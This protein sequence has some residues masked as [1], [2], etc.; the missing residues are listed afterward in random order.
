M[1]GMGPSDGTEPEPN[2]RSLAHRRRA[3]THQRRQAA[4]LR[5]QLLSAMTDPPGGAFRV[6]RNEQGRPELLSPNKVDFS[7]SHTDG[8]VGVAAVEGGHVGFDLER[9]RP[10][11]TTGD[12]LQ[13]AFDRAEWDTIT[14]AAN[15]RLMLLRLWTMKEALLKAIGI[16]LTVPLATVLAGAE[17][18]PGLL[19]L[20]AGPK[21]DP[22]GRHWRVS[23][24]TP[25]P[26]YV[27]AYAVSR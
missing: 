22:L 24:L 4:W 7:V 20:R 3:V 16:G 23:M 8:A 26:G 14:S 25:L 27:G 17:R 6:T 2:S 13:R 12:H 9:D 21:L 18:Q 10:L 11:G 15:P 5:D 1:L 19:E